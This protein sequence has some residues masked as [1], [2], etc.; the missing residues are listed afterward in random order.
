MKKTLSLA[1][2]VAVLIASFGF[3]SAVSAEETDVNM[4]GAGQLTA[5][6]DGIAL[7]AGG[8]IVEMSGNGI[9]WVKDVAGNAQITV[10]GFGKKKEFADGWTQYSGLF[11]SAEI[12]GSN[13]KIVIA[14]VG[15]DLRAK[16]R[17]RVILW[18]HGTY[19]VNGIS[20]SWATDE[21]GKSITIAPP[22]E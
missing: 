4:H 20:G 15:I 11:G 6:G 10:K 7:L 8:G 5:H 13:V 1:L 19:E 3:A 17:G 21:L 12:K 2:V 14:G 9:L 22:S 18:G 16:G